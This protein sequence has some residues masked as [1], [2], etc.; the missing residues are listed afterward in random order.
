MSFVRMFDRARGEMLLGLSGQA[1]S[2]KDTCAALLM[3][4]GF[5][6]VAFADALREEVAEAWR[7]DQRMLTDRL[8]KE[9]AIPALAIANCAEAGFIKAMDQL[10]E[11]LQAPRSARWVLQRWGTEYRR[12]TNSNY[13]IYEALQ[14]IRRLRAAGWHR[15][16]I[17]DVRFFNE[18]HVVDSLG[19]AVVRVVRPDLP[20][21]EASTVT[22][23]SEAGALPHSGGVVHNDGTLEQLHAELLRV[24]Q[25][26][27]WRPQEAT[28]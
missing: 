9:Y 26:I 12:A 27:G 4:E 21:L 24:L 23:P 28:A 8:T 1:G 10:G 13:W 14:R 11:D 6:S 16:C 3:Q 2:G 5:R 7:V 20:R 15:I 17:T 19:G 22:H 25:I 18:A